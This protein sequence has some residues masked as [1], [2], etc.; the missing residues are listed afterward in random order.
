[1]KRSSPN[2]KKEVRDSSWKLIYERF[3]PAEEGLREALCTLGNGYFGTRGAVSESGASRKHY[4]GTYIAGVYNRLPTRIAGRTIINE[5]FVNCPNWLPLTF[6]FAKGEWISPTNNTI[7][8]YSQELNLRKGVFSRVMRFRESRGHQVRVQTQRIVSMSEPHLAAIKYTIIPDN[9]E[10]WITISSG[11]DGTVQNTGVSRYRQLNSKHLRPSGLGSFGKSGIYLSMKTSQSEIEIAEAAQVRIFC[12]G[13]LIRPESKIVKKGKK[14]IY[15][16]FKIFAH[17]GK[18]YEIEKVVAIYTSKD[19]QVSRPLPAAINSVK[20]SQ[21]FS[22]LLKGHQQAWDNLWKKLDI[23]IEG[24]E[25]S[26]KVLRLHAFH[27]LQCASRHNLNLDASL[28]AR[29]LHGEAYR[30]HIFWDILFARPFFDFHA[31]E[32]SKALFLYRYRRLDQARKNARKSGYDGAMFPWQSGS[33]GREETQ[34]IHLN[35]LSGKWGP[36]HSHNQRHVS[37]AIAYDVW[38]YWERTADLDF[39]INYGAELLLSIATFGGSLAQYDSKDGRYHT[40]GLMGPDEFHERFPG[41]P[42]SGFKDNAY[43]NFLIVWTLLK[44]EEV[45]TILPAGQ[46]QRIIKKLKISQ[47][48]LNRWEDISRKMTLIINKGG[49]ISQ[50]DGYFK[51]KELDWPAYRRKYGK[52]QRI[53]RILKAEGKS[54]NAYKIAKQADVLMMF[55]LFSLAEIKDLFHRL[56]YRLTKEALKKNYGYYVLRT[57]HG[58]TLSKVVHCYL[59]YLLGKTKEAGELFLQVLKSDIYDTQGGTTPEGIHAGVMG[60]SVDLVLRAFAGVDVENNQIKVQPHLPKKWRSIKFKICYKRHWISFL[61][62]RNQASIFFPDPRS[63]KVELPFKV[64]GQLHYLQ[65]AKLHKIS[66]KRIPQGRGVKMAKQKILVVDGDITHSE[67]LKMRLKA[68]GYLVDCV[69]TAGEALGVLQS[70]W[71]DLIVMAVV[72][73]GRRH[74]FQLFREIKSNKKFASIPIIVQSNKTGMRRMFETMGAEAFFA[75]P[76]TVELLLDRIKEEVLYGKD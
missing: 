59:A 37:F 49:I 16:E 5:D 2:H 50:F 40:E 63:E 62:T 3:L 6:R 67:M 64:N 15:Q 75:K 30:G 48:E 17:K 34:V 68:K 74:G 44:A 25:F 69:H 76:Y 72:L 8:S 47:E 19:R 54:P 21:N 23:Q 12:S 4:P 55:Y 39:L 27:L 45:L 61:I 11:L 42:K 31:P 56:D 60:S 26:Q 66:L 70:G 18:R 41:A 7:L 53:D 65:S 13:R 1:M 36:D 46:K 22:R 10:G 33:T 14:G 58:S 20:R 52:I 28:P 24:D 73:R 9:Y 43:T 51:L 38:R 32:I 29:G 57:S 35:P 71:V